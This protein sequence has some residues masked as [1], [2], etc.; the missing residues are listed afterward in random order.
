MGS[1]PK[2]SLIHL[3]TLSA[4]VVVAADIASVFGRV[5]RARKRSTVG[6][7]A[8]QV[9]MLTNVEYVDV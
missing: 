6:I 1:D 4:S 2:T 5:A 3:Q 7:R 9:S 8:P